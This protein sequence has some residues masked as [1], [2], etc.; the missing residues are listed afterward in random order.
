V[1]DPKYKKFIII[2]AGPA[3]LTCA[4]KLSEEVNDILILEQGNQVG[5]L[6]KTI[7]FAGIK[8][9]IGG[10]RFI[11]KSK[12][13]FNL[14]ESLLGSDFII[15]P[16][17]SFILFKNRIFKYPVDIINVIQN[18]EFH[19]IILIVFYYFKRQLFK[20]SPE[21]TY[22]DWMINRFG[23]KL[24]DMFFRTYTEKVW[25]IKVNK[26]S[27]DWA[28]QRVKTLDLWNVIKSSIFPNLRKEHKTLSESFYYPR[29]GPGMLWEKMR[30]I[31]IQRKVQIIMNTKVLKI[32]KTKRNYEVY[33]ENDKYTCDT[34][35]SSMPLQKLIEVTENVDTQILNES[36]NLEY[37]DF[38]T[39][40]LIAK[41][42]DDRGA[43]WM[44]IHDQ[45]VKTARI[46]FYHNWSPDM[47]S[48]GLK[49]IGLEYFVFKNDN[50][51]EKTD[52]EILSIAKKE[53]DKLGLVPLNLIIDG[54]VIRESFAYP[55]YKENYKIS[56][57]KIRKHLKKYY[58]NLYTI[59]RGG[60]HRWNNQDHSMMTGIIVA[61]KI[62][63]Q[64]ILDEWSINND[65]EFIESER[66]V[67]N[68]T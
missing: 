51:W 25:G 27:K 59:G 24:F 61:K 53:C 26:I 4:Y 8:A 28:V 58:K 36:K 43:T 23:D 47:V 14:W 18:L 64:N 44:Y 34:V 54:K 32:V 68:Q 57:D 16:R 41:K 56:L 9:D 31:L 30:D 12:E 22:E 39:V 20:I 65:A 42:I 62:L 19:E 67:P 48:Q 55:V 6:S 5:G 63:G 45:D 52:M 66:L 46:Q 7:N 37:R 35:I 33:S 11:T 15:R 2:G 17:K 60:M 40:I 49:A 10:H 13:I 50:F 3:G 29:F 1:S 21:K 38:I